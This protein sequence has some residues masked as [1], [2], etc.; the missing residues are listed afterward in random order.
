ML[1]NFHL[2]LDCIRFS[3]PSSCM[4]HVSNH[5]RNIYK[6]GSVN[7]IW[8][9]SREGRMRKKKEQL[10]MYHYVYIYIS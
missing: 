7:V 4:Y 5:L 8:S 6:S 9:S 10:V 1:Y 2:N 3:Y